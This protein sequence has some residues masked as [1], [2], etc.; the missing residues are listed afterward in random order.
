M[1]V[2]KRFSA[3]IL[4]TVAFLLMG[5]GYTGHFRI[6][7]DAELSYSQEMN[8]FY[9]WTDMLAA[10][11]SDAD[12]RKAWDPTE[13]PKHYIDIDNYGEFLTTGAI[14]QSLDSLIAAHGYAFVYNQGILPWATITAFDS[15][16]ACLERKDEAKAILFAADLGHY[17]A[18]GH[19]PLHIT[20]NYNG[21]YSGNDGIHS[22]YESQMINQ[23]ISQ[24]PHEG[25][26]PPVVGDIPGFV[27]GYLYEN[28]NYIDSLLAADDHATATAGNTTSPAYYSA[29]W[30]KSKS[31][32]EDLFINASHA[33]ATL[34]Y[35]AWLNAGSPVLTTGAA[36]PEEGRKCRIETVYPNPFSESF[37]FRIVLSEK[38][39]VK[40]Y[41]A[42]VN[43]K[44]T[45]MLTDE[46]FPRGSF[47]AEWHCEGLPAGI[48]FV[49]M[50][51]GDSVSV[52]KIL[53]TE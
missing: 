17:V 21:Q 52:G 38:K 6:N 5:W 19:M 13:A 20:R 41:L 30:E 2:R 29:L 45:R 23:Y 50:D 12:E 25:Y 27:F 33:L 28:Y 7:K 4:L 40:L 43:G 31:F 49:V 47:S 18:D 36:L 15:L 34:I 35:N 39:H 10:H 37:R 53:K 48:Y 11:A 51:T 42:D 24:I 16:T 46:E 26:P 44:I 32:T 9:S 14:S 8:H 3:L 22:R 1:T